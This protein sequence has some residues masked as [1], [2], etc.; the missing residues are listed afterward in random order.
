MLRMFEK[1]VLRRIFRPKRDQITGEWRKLYNEV[2][3]DLHSSQNIICMI[4]SRSMR[5][6]GACSMYGGEEMCI[7]DFGGETLRERDPLENAGIDGSIIL[8]WIF[9]K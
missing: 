2:L 8:R 7:Q 6:M 9:R 3:N 4:K 5:W 1:R